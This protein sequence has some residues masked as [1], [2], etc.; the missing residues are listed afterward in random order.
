MRGRILPSLNSDFHRL[1]L[2]LLSIHPHQGVLQY[3]V[4]PLPWETPRKS[5]R[6]MVLGTPQELSLTSHIKSRM[7]ISLVILLVIQNLNQL[8]MTRSLSVKSLLMSLH[9]LYVQLLLLKH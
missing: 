9:Q 3:Y 4:Q 8:T 2:H 7:E 6:Q 5:P 1:K